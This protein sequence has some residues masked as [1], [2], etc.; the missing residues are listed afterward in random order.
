MS[1]ANVFITLT[2]FVA[3]VPMAKAQEYHDYPTFLAILFVAVA[4]VVS[5]LFQS[6]KHG[7]HGFNCPEQTSYWLTKIDCFGCVI[8][9]IRMLMIT[10][11]ATFRAHGEMI[12]MT[13]VLNLISEYDQTPETKL[14][15]LITHSLWHIFVF[16]LLGHLLQDVYY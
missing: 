9:L 13:F 1:A 11:I 15:F 14:F 7:M 16:I 8:L 12:I 5:H 3:I 2:S 10:P 4:S 6:D